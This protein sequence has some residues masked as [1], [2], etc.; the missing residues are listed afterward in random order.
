MSTIGQRIK[1]KRKEMNLT[2][3]DIQSITGISTGNMSDLENDKYMPSVVTLQSIS[4]VLA[5][6]IDWLVNGQEY[7]ISELASGSSDNHPV[8]PDDLELLEKFHQLTEKEQI[9]I[10]GMIEGMLMSRETVRQPDKQSRSK[11]IGGREE[12]A[13]S[14]TA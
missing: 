2:M 14:E 4:K 5:V 1:R 3:K 6:S 10:E 7:Q 8:G 11:N 13:A 9:K 12:A